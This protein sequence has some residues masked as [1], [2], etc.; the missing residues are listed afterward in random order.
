[1][2][3][4]FISIFQLN[5]ATI[6]VERDVD[7]VGNEDSTDVKTDEFYRP[8]VLS[9]KTEYEVSIVLK[10]FCDDYLCVCACVRAHECVVH[11]LFRYVV[12]C[13]ESSHFLEMFGKL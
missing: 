10:C 2:Y 7:V 4:F 9:I 11:A 6:K 3:Y 12:L 5:T 8:S 13:A 1:L